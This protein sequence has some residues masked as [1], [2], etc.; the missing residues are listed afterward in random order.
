MTEFS[1]LPEP[2]RLEQICR[3]LAMLD[4]A[5]C[6]EW[7]YRYYSFNSAWSGEQRLASMRNGEGDEWFLVFE[8]SGTFL[9][10]FWHEYEN[11]ISK[12]IYTGIKKELEPLVEEPAFSMEYITYGGWHDGKKWHLRGNKD[13]FKQEIEIL[14]GAPS[15]YRDYA[16]QYFEADLS[17]ETISSI[18]SGERLTVELLAKINPKRIFDDL[19]ADLDEIGY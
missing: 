19:S 15:A 4:A 17:T 1:D 5:L 12:Q 7:E 2:K 11:E 8:P 16:A 3:G 10:T 18:L 14:S 6:E 9:K 13:P